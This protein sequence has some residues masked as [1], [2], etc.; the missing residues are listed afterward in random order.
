VTD[1]IA[2]DTN[3]LVYAADAQESAKKERAGQ[4]IEVARRTHAQ[5]PQQVYGEFLNVSLKRGQASRDLALR[6]IDMWQNFFPPIPTNMSDLLPA[7]ALAARFQLQ[8]WDALIIYVCRN[9][10]ISFLFSED[11][12]DGLTL[13]GLRV[14]NP[15]NPDND[16]ILKPLL[17]AAK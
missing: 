1:R 6:H 10:R 17:K 13:G 3:I 15:F 16:D 12:Q 11:M 4:I 5:I 7:F 14:V 9:A 8:Y 2:F